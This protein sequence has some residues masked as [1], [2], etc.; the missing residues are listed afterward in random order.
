MKSATFASLPAPIAVYCAPQSKSYMDA[1]WRYL[2][3]RLHHRQNLYSILQHSYNSD[4]LSGA[5]TSV[6]LWLWS[7]YCNGMQWLWVPVRQW[8]A[9]ESKLLGPLGCSQTGM[10]RPL[11]LSNVYQNYGNNNFHWY[12]TDQE[13]HCSDFS[14]Y[15]YTIWKK[16]Q[17]KLHAKSAWAWWYNVE[18]NV[19]PSTFPIPTFSADAYSTRT[20]FSKDPGSALLH[21]GISVSDL[22]EASWRYPRVLV[23]QHNMIS[24]FIHKMIQ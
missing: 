7:I 21:V 13:S 22:W 2:T 6:W 10:I 23:L 20:T 14:S 17:A 12:S 18:I 9:V 15:S 1:K 16:G 24:R 4:Q 3:E 8:L 5:A 19:C 11:G